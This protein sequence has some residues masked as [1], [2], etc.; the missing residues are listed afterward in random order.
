MIEGK[1]GRGGS[2]WEWWDKNVCD[3][4]DGMNTFR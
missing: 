4:R 1:G 3:E 2:A